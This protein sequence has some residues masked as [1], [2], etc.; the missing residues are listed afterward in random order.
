MLQYL[1]AW[2]AA[3]PDA[4]SRPEAIRRLIEL[5]LEASQRHDPAGGRASKA[6]KKPPGGT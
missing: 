2:I 5:G 3:R 1:D 6:T 4:T